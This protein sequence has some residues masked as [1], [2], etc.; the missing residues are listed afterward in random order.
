MK[1]DKNSPVANVLKGKVSDYKSKSQWIW[2]HGIVI[3]EVEAPPSISQLCNSIIKVGLVRHIKAT[4]RFTARTTQR[5]EPPSRWNPCSI[6]SLWNLHTYLPRR[7]HNL[8]HGNL[9]TLH[10]G[11]LE[12]RKKNERK[13]ESVLRSVKYKH[14]KLMQTIKCK[15]QVLRE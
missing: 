7:M 10:T 14:W 11:R 1:S 3:R 5:T 13:K 2:V 12:E 9:R 15:S 6:A 8:F 4:F